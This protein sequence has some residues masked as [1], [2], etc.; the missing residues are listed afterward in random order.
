MSAQAIHGMS[1]TRTHDEE[2]RQ[3]YYMAIRRHL[4]LNVAGGNR[5]AYATLA[6]PAFTKAHGRHPENR[7]EVRSVMTRVPYYQMYSAMQRHTQEMTWDSV[8]DSVER[9]LLHLND[10]VRKLAGRSGGTLRLDP[11]FKVPPY[12]TFY[13]IHLQPGGYH[14]ALGPDDVSAGALY[15]RATYMYAMGNLG[16]QSDYLGRSLLAHYRKRFP[17]KTPRRI[18]DMGCTTGN[19]TLPWAE[20]FPDADVHGIDVGESVL[21]YAHARSESLGVR[22]HYSQQNAERT[23]FPDASFDVVVSHIIMHE[24]STPAVPRIFAESRRLLAAGG[25]MMHMDNPR[26]CELPPFDAFLAEWE[27]HN[28]NEKFGGTYRDMDICAEARKAGFCDANVAL[29]YVELIVPARIMN[30]QTKGIVFPCLVGV[31]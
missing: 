28:N 21:R 2:A 19:S 17:G 24:T 7:S 29:E 31:T 22:A 27:V 13:D 16:P 8:I 5:A 20:A 1:V 30:Y 25:V 18:L 12:L 4:A 14:A 15:D 23:D 10:N 3:T 6:R 11:D 9:Q 26:L